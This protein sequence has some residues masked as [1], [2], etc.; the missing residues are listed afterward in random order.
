MIRK[1]LP[2]FLSFV[3]LFTNFFGMETFA[4]SNSLET[5]IN[6]P[7]FNSYS[8]NIFYDK[9]QEIG[10]NDEEILEL[11]QNESDRIG[12]D[13]KL[14]SEL[15][16]NLGITFVETKNPNRYSAMYLLR[17]TTTD[18]KS[19][20]VSLDFAEISRNL[21]WV[22]GVSAVTFITEQAGKKAFAK[23]FAQE[24]IKKLGIAIA[25][26]GAIASISGVIFGEMSRHNNGVTVNFTLVTA[27]DD[28]DGCKDILTDTSHYFW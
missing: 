28:Y 14:P 10:F 22:G 7:N 4:V 5:Q 23:V 8:S 12:L 20:S 3:L 26:V 19:Y 15:S 17:G 2:I 13:L 21:G 25:W 18:S 27:C 9:L 6:N 11:Y 1:F 16:E 24:A